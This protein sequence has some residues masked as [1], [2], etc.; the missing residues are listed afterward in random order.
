MC[1]SYASKHFCFNQLKFCGVLFFR[2]YSSVNDFS[3]VHSHAERSKNSNSSIL[4]I[5]RLLENPARIEHDQTCLSALLR[6]KELPITTFAGM[7]IRTYLRKIKI[8]NGRALGGKGVRIQ[9]EICCLTGSIFVTGLIPLFEQWAGI[10][11][12]KDLGVRSQHSTF[13][14]FQRSVPSISPIPNPAISPP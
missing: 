4:F 5:I 2:L 1:K 6:F 14:V 10:D 13:E 3:S 8:Q 12:N 7:P 9:G 11:D